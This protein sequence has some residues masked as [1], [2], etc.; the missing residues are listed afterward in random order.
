MLKKS[1]LKPETSDSNA[2]E[3]VSVRFEKLHNSIFTSQAVV[4]AGSDKR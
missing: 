4:T 1:Y 3:P 2:N